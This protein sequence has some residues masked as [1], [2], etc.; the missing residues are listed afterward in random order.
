MLSLGFC[1]LDAYKP[2]R[3]GSILIKLSPWGAVS[4]CHPT[5]EIDAAAALMLPTSSRIP[6]SQRAV[7]RSPSTLNTKASGRETEVT[8]DMCQSTHP[9]EVQIHFTYPDTQLGVFLHQ[10]VLTSVSLDHEVR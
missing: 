4:F 9:A 10:S 5:A 6:A 1:Q 7:R 2:N 3:R 8:K